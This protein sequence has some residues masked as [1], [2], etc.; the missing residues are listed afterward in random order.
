MGHTILHSFL[1]LIL[2]MYVYV[3]MHGHVSKWRSVTTLCVIPQAL[4]TI[5]DETESLIHLEPHQ[6]WLPLSFKRPPRIKT[7]TMVDLCG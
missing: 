4:S 2:C 5:L 1:P 6:D 3:H 7:A